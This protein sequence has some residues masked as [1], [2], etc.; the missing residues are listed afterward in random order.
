MKEGKE[1]WTKCNE[2]ASG[3][4]LLYNNIIGD[5]SILKT[6]IAFSASLFTR[7]IHENKTDMTE[8]RLAYNTVSCVMRR[9]T[10]LS[11]DPLLILNVGHVVQI[12]LVRQLG[13]FFWE[14]DSKLRAKGPMPRWF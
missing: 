13:G 9:R 3:R 1:R 10:S 5:I 2:S 12:I 14:R 4:T 8:K 11:P 6:T 7:N